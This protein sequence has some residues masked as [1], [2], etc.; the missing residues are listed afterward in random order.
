M[1]QTATPVP[2]LELDRDEVM[3]ISEH[4]VDRPMQYRD[5]GRMFHALPTKNSYR[6]IDH[7]CFGFWHLH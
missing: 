4:Q 5:L 7:F 2:S 6:G 1:K 3:A